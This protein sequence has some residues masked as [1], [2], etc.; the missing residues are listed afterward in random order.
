MSLTSDVATV[1]SAYPSDCRPERVESLESA[2][3]F[4]GGALWKVAAARGTL[5]LRR[6]PKERREGRHIQT[7]HAVLRHAWQQGFSSVPVPIRAR[8]G[9]TLIE[10]GGCYW[11]LAPW[12]PGEATFHADPNAARLAAAMQ[13]LAKFHLAAATFSNARSA[14]APSPGIAMRLER[15]RALQERGCA[16]I[17]ASLANGR[18]GGALLAEL[19]P[20]ARRALELFRLCALLVENR[21]AAATA[22]VVP[23]QPC[24]RDIWHDHVLFTGEAVTGII[25]FGAMRTDC[26]VTDVTRLLGSLVGDDESAWK[27]GLE[28]YGAVRPLTPAES[29]LVPVFDQSAVLL[30][31]MN[32]LEWLFVD[33]RQFEQPQRVRERLDVTMRRLEHLS[34]KVNRGAN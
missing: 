14:P 6:W 15:L 25:D 18:A 13:A 23:L 29:G 31:P 27:S 4:S 33:R 32:W 12:M 16:A 3:G 24:I 34:V 28:T 20:I 2:G 19:H 8:D 10:R 17:E 21:L 30:S 22:V 9:A 1:L 7:I 11:E 5:C 26:V